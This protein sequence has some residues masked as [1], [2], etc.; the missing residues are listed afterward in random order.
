M[1]GIVRKSGGGGRRP[2]SLI[3][4][5]KTKSKVPGTSYYK[6][7]NG[8]Y[9]N[10]KGKFVKAAAVKRMKANRGSGSLPTYR[11]GK[12]VTASA[13]KKT[14]KK[15]TVAAAAAA[16]KRKSPVKKVT[17]KRKRRKVAAT[18][19][20]VKRKR[21][22][23]AAAAAPVKR[24]RRK[25]RK[26]STAAKTKR[27]GSTAVA[28][29]KTTKAK[30]SVRQKRS[31]RRV[32]AYLSALRSGKSKSSAKRIALKKVPLSGGD[33]FKGTMRV[34][35][36]SEEK[37]RTVRG[38]KYVANKRKKRKTKRKAAS[39]TT[40]RRRRLAAAKR[41]P[42]AA[43]RRRVASKR[44]RVA[45]RRVT[46]KATTRRKTM[47]RN[48]LGS[49]RRNASG[50]VETF[51]SV[52]VSGMFVTV[53]FLAHKVIT[54]LICDPIFKMFE[55]TPEEKTKREEEE[56]KIVS[57]GGKVEP[58]KFNIQQ[59]KKPI[60]GAGVLL[61]AVPVLTLVKEKNRAAELGAGMVAS[62]LHSLLVSVSVHS[63]N[64]EF[65]KAVGEVPMRSDWTGRQWPYRSSRASALAGRRRAMGNNMTSVGPRYAP[66]NRLAGMGQV[67][68]AAAGSFQQAAAGTG[69]AP[70][71]QQ[72]A[73]G[74]RR[75]AGGGMGEYFTPM[76]ATG[77]YFAP[78][79]TQGVGA[80]E[81]A[82]PLAMPRNNQVIQDGIRP[83]SNLDREMCIMEAAAGLRGMGEYFGAS[84][85][86]QVMTA[87][88]E[89]Q[90]IP[91]G[92]VWAG[93]L[94]VD[95]KQMTSELSAGILNIPGGNGTLSG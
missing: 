60:C 69:R 66:V 1:A 58:S 17:V 40:K 91:N 6:T 16:P 78:S 18:A 34:G 67:Y 88:Q 82:G 36:I 20:P 94:S 4:S 30:R 9:Q 62:W 42:V 52:M 71:F 61:V 38:T 75:S 84:S 63:G 13:P 54:N 10:A 47:R 64:V 25:T 19:T 24:K 28:K 72:A 68:Q 44:R 12:L 15:K 39:A 51:K 77:E 83:D 33:S 76:N 92:D 31:G 32:A 70:G 46:R 89:S 41:R 85:D 45:S 55:E 29:K 7:S 74:F 73:A 26:S 53:G 35:T 59:W 65:V 80:Y 27:K 22:K 21:R 2:V 79:S 8:R 57:G 86:G 81:E 37:S 43:K 49:Y 93:E 23:V 48:A 95:D 5:S 90:W 50:W 56:A 3:R 87:G 14:Q 11:G